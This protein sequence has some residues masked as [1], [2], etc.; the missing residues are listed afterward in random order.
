MNAP[1]GV[2]FVVPFRGGA[3][4]LEETL[5]AI[6]RQRHSGPVEIIVVDDE[7][8]FDVEA[9]VR[10]SGAVARVVAGPGRGAAAA[11]NTGLCAASH[12]FICQI[13]QDVVLHDGWL[14][15]ILPAFADPTVAAVQGE[16]V[17]DGTGSLLARVMAADLSARYERIAG[18]RMTH[19]CTGNVAYRA[20]ALADIGGFDESLGYGYDNDVSY[21]LQAAGYRLEFCRSA[22]SVHRWRS[23]VGGYLAQQYGFGY[24]RLDVVRKHPARWSGDSV[25][26]WRMMAHA[27]LMLVAMASAAAA[28]TAELA[29][30]PSQAFVA[31]SSA[32]V[33][34]L[35][36][37]RA[38]AGIRAARRTANPI[39]LL[40]PLVHLARDAAWGAAII[41]WMIR[42]ATRSGSDPSHSMR[43]RAVRA[44]G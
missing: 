39:A 10:A 44:G 41:V 8:M 27:P 35:A 33:G 31:V 37:E 24:G 17:Q 5:V 36:V 7:K 14:D 34:V 21:R 2:T 9:A 19:V 42:R 4:F 26:S 43:P 16:Y 20:A 18:T 12:P 13:D 23:G 40:F 38:V 1:N 11:L 32:I 28:A 15:A 29:G 22:R 6:S 3:G 25:S 30:F